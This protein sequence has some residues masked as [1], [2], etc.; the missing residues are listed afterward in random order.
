MSND[1]YDQEILPLYEYADMTVPEEVLLD[2]EHRFPS[3][4]EAMREGRV[5]LPKNIVRDILSI[6]NPVRHGDMDIYHYV[7]VIRYVHK[8][9]GMCGNYGNNVS[10][11]QLYTI[12]RILR[13]NM[14]HTRVEF[15]DQ[16]QTMELL[17]H[18]LWRSNENQRR[19]VRFRGIHVYHF[20][21]HDSYKLILE[22]MSAI[23]IIH[24]VP[25]YRL[26]ERGETCY[27]I[28]RYAYRQIQQEDPTL[29]ESTCDQ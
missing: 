16:P 29:F 26:T 3:F 18:S 20:C 17:Q 4:M 28:L 8:S 13:T 7:D 19:Y 11:D 25:S 23:G 22:L 12:M 21:L 2:T 6:Y 1:L 10:M 9:F 15:S 14:R 27:R 5:I 24:R